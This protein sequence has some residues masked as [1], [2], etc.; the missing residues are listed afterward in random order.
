MYYKDSSLKSII[1]TF[2]EAAMN[3][4]SEALTFVRNELLK[5]GVPAASFSSVLSEEKIEQVLL[6][7]LPNSCI[8]SANKKSGGHQTHIHVTGEGME[9]FFSPVALAEAVLP[10]DDTQVT[11]DLFQHNLEFIN[12][13]NLSEGRNFS[14]IGFSSTDELIRSNTY[15]KL[16]IR[17][18]GSKQV[19]LSKTTMDG[20]EFLYLRNNLYEGDGLVFLKPFTPSKYYAVAIPSQSLEGIWEGYGYKYYVSGKR[21]TLESV[22]ASINTQS[23]AS[24]SFTAL[25]RTNSGAI[26][27]HSTEEAE[28]GEAVL[29][30]LSEDINNRAQR[31]ANHRQAIK[32]LAYN[33]ERL[34]FT[35]FECDIDCLGVKPEMPILIFEIKTLD[36][37]P[38][39]ET[40][41]MLKAFAQL[42]CYEEFKLGEFT[43]HATQKIV[44][45]SQAPANKKN[46]RFL[47]KNNILV[48]WINE[49]HQLD[50]SQS[51]RSKMRVWGI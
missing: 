34:G 30:Y 22:I 2:K 8:V 15:K 21:K 13:R 41:Q 38:A 17:G 31:N 50:G 44:L 23:E 37:S 48:M 40:S 11:V 35:L 43:G 26:A 36:G 9:M 16:A 18:A 51:A 12:R 20:N 19:Q 14:R 33:L 5:Q 49:L 1:F 47:E 27:D 28:N 46:V 29:L 10:I 45:F 42:Y 39:D 25:R 4:L 32:I 6:L 24:C 7:R 3:C